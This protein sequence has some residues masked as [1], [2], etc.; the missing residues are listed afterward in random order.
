MR[1]V[2]SRLRSTSVK[3]DT[4]R[5]EALLARRVPNLHRDQSLIHCHLQRILPA[6]TWREIVRRT[7]RWEGGGGG[8][9]QW[10]GRKTNLLG[11]EISADGGLVLVRELLVDILVHK[12]CLADTAITENDNLQQH[13]LARCRHGERISAICYPFSE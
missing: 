9:V 4:K 2:C 12:R 8:A 6:V 11:Q 3:G 13:L 10:T 1:A 5:L 7:A